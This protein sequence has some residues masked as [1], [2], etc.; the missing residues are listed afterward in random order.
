MISKIQKKPSA[1]KREH[2][3]KFLNFFYFCRSFLP[4]WIRIWIPNPDP[5]TDPLTWLNP[6]PKHWVVVGTDTVHDDKNFTFF[7]FLLI[8]WAGFISSDL[9]RLHRR[10]Q[11]TGGSAGHGRCGLETNSELEIFEQLMYSTSMLQTE[12]FYWISKLSSLFLKLE[13]ITYVFAHDVRRYRKPDSYFFRSKQ[14]LK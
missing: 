10:K 5:D 4:A 2:P 12:H 6:D 3:V 1:L 8:V 7:E 13:R 9:F 14:G 11:D